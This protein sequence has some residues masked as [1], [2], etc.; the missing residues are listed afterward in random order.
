MTALLN[1]LPRHGA[2]VLAMAA[3]STGTVACATSVEGARSSGVPNHAPSA[4]APSTAT[5]RATPSAGGGTPTGTDETP[6]TAPTGAG[7]PPDTDTST[8][9]TS[10]ASASTVL[11]L[12][13]IA[14]CHTADLKAGFDA[15]GGAAPD[16]SSTRQT[17]A[18]VY[19]TNISRHTCSL[20]GFPGVDIVGDRGTDGTWSLTRSSVSPT[21]ILLKPSNTASF[22]ITLLPTA[23]PAAEAFEP[24]LVRITPPDEE[25]Q[26]ALK[27]PWGGS[28]VRQDA[29]TH[30]GTFVNP[31]GS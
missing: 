11:D 8:A 22:S 17:R 20:I 12:T 7:A 4:P 16:M 27:W 14:R 24:A 18:S 21:K 30:P 23:A 10:T 13:S 5:P 6:S 15:A 31:V 25:T 3:L 2:A 26:F 9:D 29:A 19:F 1:R 28:I